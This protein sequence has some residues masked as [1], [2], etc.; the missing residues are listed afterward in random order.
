MQLH[1]TAWATFGGN[2]NHVIL[3]NHGIFLRMTATSFGLRQL[4]PEM[5][6]T[7]RVA[8]RG[9][10]KCKNHLAAIIDPILDHSATNT[11]RHPSTCI[12]LPHLVIMSL[13]G[14]TR[15]PPSNRL[16]FKPTVDPVIFFEKPASTPLVWHSTNLKPSV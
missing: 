6:A 10:L 4:S 14:P 15:E 12:Q 2:S 8:S 3:G 16:T 7:R 13:F 9:S 11:D 5:T 1:H